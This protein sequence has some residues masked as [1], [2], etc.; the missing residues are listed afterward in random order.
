MNFA[1][2]F[3][4]GLRVRVTGK[5]VKIFFL[6]SLICFLDEIVDRALIAITSLNLAAIR[7]A[8]TL[9]VF[10]RGLMER[11]MLWANYLYFVLGFY[12]NNLMVF[13]LSAMDF[14]SALNE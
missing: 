11:T 1:L 9:Q 8:L 14:S 13:I 4:G 7:T 2:Y 5:R 6:V 10:I 3:N 12:V